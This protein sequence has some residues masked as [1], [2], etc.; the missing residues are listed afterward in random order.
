MSDAD[1]F[2]TLSSDH[3]RNR[4][5]IGRIIA[6]L[7]NGS[8]WN[9]DFVSI[10]SA[11]LAQFAFAINGFLLDW[12]KP[13][14]WLANGNYKVIVFHVFKHR[15]T[16]DGHS[17][18]LTVQWRMKTIAVFPKDTRAHE[19]DSGT[20][21]RRNISDV[22]VH[23]RSFIFLLCF[24]RSVNRANEGHAFVFI[25]TLL[26]CSVLLGLLFAAL[27][28]RYVICVGSISVQLHCRLHFFKRNTFDLALTFFCYSN[29][30]S[31]ELFAPWKSWTN[32]TRSSGIFNGQFVS[33][34]AQ[35]ERTMK[36][37]TCKFGNKNLIRC[38]PS[39]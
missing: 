39:T 23:G 34:C 8:N 11:G 26:G 38:S 36:Q 5:S 1:N 35:F 21:E 6:G 30:T 27:L 17:G 25:D 28:L 12:L 20:R 14:E 24:S 4:I 32:M 15:F 13:L 31:A 19:N 37:I 7:R 16:V 10:V 9:S 29:Y 22:S 2:N 33:C 3:S 18:H